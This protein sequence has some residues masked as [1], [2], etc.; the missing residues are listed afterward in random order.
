M[1]AVLVGKWYA[2]TLLEDLVAFALLAGDTLEVAHVGGHHGLSE[3]GDVI[4][5][6]HL[7]AALVV[8]D[9]QLN[10]SS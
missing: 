8:L 10:K 6:S 5:A 4:D 9:E 2:K 7:R 1:C 3:Q